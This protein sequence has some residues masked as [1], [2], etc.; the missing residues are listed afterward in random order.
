MKTAL[1]RLLAL[2]T[3]ATSMSCFAAAGD[4]K[5]DAANT[6]AAKQDGCADSAKHAKKQKQEKKTQGDDQSEKDFDRVL[7]GIYG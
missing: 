6:T 3:L 2:A 1:I 7:M 4:S 5:H